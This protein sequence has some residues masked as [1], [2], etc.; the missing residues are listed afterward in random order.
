MVLALAPVHAGQRRATLDAF[1]GTLRKLAAGEVAQRDI[2]EIVK[3]IR[4]AHSGELVDPQRLP[5]AAA[6]LLEGM[7]VCSVAEELAEYDAVTLDAVCGVARQVHASSL[8]MA[9]ESADHLGYARATHDQYQIVG[10]SFRSDADPGTALIVGHD[11]VSLIQGPTVSTVLFTECAAL[12]AW[13]DG[14]RIFI[15]NDGVACGVR[16]TQYALGTD[17][18]AR[19]DAAVP[20][21]RTVRMPG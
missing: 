17:A 21:D 7:P 6:N 1:C 5:V 14:S 13:A 4:E 10:E 18:I 9:P 16:P 12:L 11:G 3:E 15:G 2:D 8:L 19:L 20:P